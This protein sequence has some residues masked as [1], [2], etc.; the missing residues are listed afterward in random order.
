MLEEEEEKEKA[1]KGLDRSHNHL[2]GEQEIGR[3][4]GPVSKWVSKKSSWVGSRLLVL[5]LA[6][7]L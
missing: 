6:V 1:V 2:K 5:V 4:G 7:G 3:H